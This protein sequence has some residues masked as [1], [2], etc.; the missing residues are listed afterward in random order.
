MGFFYAPLYLFIMRKFFI[1]EDEK[2]EI[3]SMYG[4]RSLIN[5]SEDDNI[6]SYIDSYLNS[7][8]C[9]EIANDMESLKN[10]TMYTSLNKSDKEI[11]DSAIIGLNNPGL[12]IT[13]KKEIEC[14]VGLFGPK[15]K[16]CKCVKDYLRSQFLEKLNTDRQKV[17]DQ[18]CAFTTIF[19]P[20]TQLEVCKKEEL[21]TT[22]TQ[23]STIKPTPKEPENTQNSIP[24]QDNTVTPTQQDSENTQSTTPNTQTQVQ[25]STDSS[26][27]VKTEK[28]AET[29]TTST[30]KNYSFKYPGDK[31]YRYAVLNGNWWAKNITNNREFELTGKDYKDKFQISINN[32]DKQFPDARPSGSPHK[33]N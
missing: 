15:E 4:L 27:T 29:T 13:I 26:T 20:N 31:N 1:T 33:E 7:K 19:P 24:N 2:K 5:E 10:T 11:Y 6:I 22:P 12:A 32:L 8:N 16:K 18:I 3:L 25:S 17:I 23:D 30:E 9:G 14:D 28:P 21:K